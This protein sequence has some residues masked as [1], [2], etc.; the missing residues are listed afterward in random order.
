ML[1]LCWC[2]RTSF[3]HIGRHHRRSAREILKDLGYIPDGE[4]MFVTR[5]RL[6]ADI[7]SAIPAENQPFRLKDVLKAI[8]LC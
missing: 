2:I 3:L 4:A 6:D 8:F 1:S 7:F 5:G